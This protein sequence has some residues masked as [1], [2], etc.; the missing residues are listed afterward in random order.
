MK[1]LK[2]WLLALM[3]VSVSAQA[4]DKPAVGA[5]GESLMTLRVDGELT[6]GTEGQVLEYKLRTQPN[7]L[8]R[9]MLAKD[10]PTWQLV[11]VLQGGRPVKARTPMR[12]TLAATEVAG[13]YEVRIDNVVFAP[14]TRQDYDEA[15]AA[16]R[17][18][19]ENGETITTADEPASAPAFITSRKMQ[20][21]SYPTGLLY[22]GVEGIVLLILRL[23]PDGTVA[24]AF[25]AQSSLLNIKGRPTIL[26]KARALLEKES[27]R[28]A[29]KWTFDIETHN[30]SAL[31]NKDMT[32]RIPVDYRL[33]DSGKKDTAPEIA[34]TWRHEF[35]GPNL[36][37]PWLRDE[38]NQQVVSVSDLAENEQISG[39][40]PFRLRDRGVLGRA[41]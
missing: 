40:S 16:E 17:A 39:T 18:A 25:A 28:A 37:A 6:I 7:Q 41:L 4:G 34:G 2:A 24:E 22:A 35:R 33:S 10:I 23:N 1:I 31:S 8:I 29:Q 27:L 15:Q 21:P 36:T 19:F 3:L 12:I 9:D 32:L 14:L 38:K 13:G 5:V 26:D 11:P 30:P 20:P